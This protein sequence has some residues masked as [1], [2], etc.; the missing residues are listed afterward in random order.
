M[1]LALKAPAPVEFAAKAHAIT[2]R[3][4]DWLRRAE[5]SLPASQKARRTFA[6][7]YRSKGERY[8]IADYYKADFEIDV[9]TAVAKAG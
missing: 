1:G 3:Y 4:H 9:P 2:R 7:L 5:G 8:Q 6:S